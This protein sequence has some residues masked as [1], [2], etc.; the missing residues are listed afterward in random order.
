LRRA[1]PLLGILA[2]C[3]LL[4]LHFFETF[5]NGWDQ[6]EYVWCVKD[7]YLPH[8]PYVL[9]ILLGRLFHLVLPAASAL[10]LLSLVSGL[11]AVACIYLTS[12][13]LVM[14]SGSET[15][16]AARR[17]GSSAA[18]LLGLS[19]VFV[20]QVTTQEAYALQLSLLLAAAAALS[21][22]LRHRH[23][24]GGLAT[25][26]ALAAHNASI[27][28]LPA[29]AVLAVARK[30][31][32]GTLRGFSLWLGC[33]L[34]TLGLVYAI[35]LSG[36]PTESGHRTAAIVAYL[37]G[38][39]P[40][41]ELA[42]LADPGF[43]LGSATG[44]SVRIL[45]EQVVMTRGP[46]ATG[47][48]GASWQHVIAALVGL[49]T[50][51]KAPRAAA[52]WTLWSL[53]FLVYELA[54][55]WNLDYGIYLV[56]VMPALCGLCAHA[57]GWAGAQRRPFGP[58]LQLALVVVLLVPSATQ[59]AHHWGDLESD[60]RRHDSAATLAAIWA[61]RSLPENAVVIQSRGEWNANLLPLYA[62]RQHVARTGS[63]LK[64]LRDRA[65]G[66]PMK[67]DA[68]E[69]L[70]TEVLQ[71]LLR[72]GRP[73][74]AFDQAPLAGGPAPHTLDPEQFRWKAAGLVDLESA[75]SALGLEGEAWQRF[76]GRTLPV[77]QASAAP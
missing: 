53:P 1:A 54:L 12:V 75:A 37:R 68:Y 5:P 14:G 8:S 25:G 11:A 66:T 55:G 65:P 18:L 67:P 33:A 35:G 17:V 56:F 74:F 63:G 41:F 76:E 59:I 52:F 72:A 2:L 3:L 9:F 73:V 36:L 48:V 10:S 22:G 7:G 70:S 60:R 71:E 49:L 77:Y 50:L 6:A 4:P 23:A 45:S 47:P 46:L 15:S 32:S 34:L 30:G 31:E 42:S 20:R 38:M 51:W 29:L 39:P 13:R 40:A 69:L 21:S 64:L 62:E 44:L 16:W 24:W 26:C 27:F 57:G 43:V 58:I 61:A 28:L 19:T